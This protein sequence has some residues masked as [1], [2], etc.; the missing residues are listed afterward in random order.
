MV[1][2]TREEVE[3]FVG[4]LDRR[5]RAGELSWKTAVNVWTLVRRAFGDASAGKALALRVRKDDPTSGVRGPDRGVRRSKGF[6]YPAEALRLFAC[7]AV[8]LA[9][10]RMAAIALYT[11][12]R[13][14]ELRALDWSNVDVQHGT[15][16]VHATIDRKG[17]QHATKTKRGRTVPIEQTLLPLL[18]AMRQ[19]AGGEGRVIRARLGR[20][21][22]RF[23][24]S[25]LRRAGIDRSDLHVKSGDQ[26]R[27]PFRWHDLRGSFCTWAA[28]RGEDVLRIMARAGHE[29]IKTTE[30]YVVLGGVLGMALGEVFP[31]L[32]ASLLGGGGVDPAVPL[33]RG[34]GASAR[35]KSPVSRSS[36]NGPRNVPT[37]GQVRETIVGRQGLETRTTSG[38][39]EV[40]ARVGMNTA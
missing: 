33:G 4:N 1:A 13:T 26:T 32:P 15:M 24:K 27:V 30:G 6:I 9:F 35:G 36:Q 2:I 23:L 37:G 22:A 21:V 31:P 29:D 19:E 38:I 3:A 25:A 16:H 14:A 39:C 17:E 40:S 28:A 7:D 5:V 12:L 18:R 11:G 8:P 34:G 20:D 10:R